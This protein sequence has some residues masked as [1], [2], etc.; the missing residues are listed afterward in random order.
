MTEIGG[1]KDPL[2]QRP[3]A[4]R[5]LF[6]HFSQLANGFPSDAVQG[7]AANI[8]LNVL[9]QSCATQ[10]QAEAMFDDLAGKLKSILVSHY[11][12]AG[13]RRSV[14]PFHQTIDVPLIHFKK[15]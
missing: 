3:E 8:L 10:R 9:R 1:P 7:A 12:G 15:K 14:F 2:I 5:E 6:K 11:D 4:E 13:K